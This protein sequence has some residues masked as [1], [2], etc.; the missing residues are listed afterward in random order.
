MTIYVFDSGPLINL[1][2][3]YYRARFPSLWENFDGMVT[4]SR[5]LST[6][7]VYNELVDRGD[8]LS[9]WCKEKRQVFSTPDPSELGFVRSIF[10]VI[11]FQAM[12][13]KKEM[14]A[15]RP[16][17]DPFVIAKASQLAEGCVVTSEERR[18]HSAKMPDVCDHFGIDCV[19]LEEFMEREGWSF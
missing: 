18:P 17:A 6:R 14:W 13:R 2:R 11:H 15:G 5:I 12:I 19:N 10:E 8:E 3:Y 7:E 4:T 9:T 16:V 1:F